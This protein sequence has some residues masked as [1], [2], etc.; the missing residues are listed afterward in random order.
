[1]VGFAGIDRFFLSGFPAMK[2][3]GYATLTQPTTS[4]A[5]VRGRLV[6]FNGIRPIVSSP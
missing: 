3:L 2:L 6:T 4:G 1:M 5:M